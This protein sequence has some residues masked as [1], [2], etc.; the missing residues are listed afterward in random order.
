MYTQMV[1]LEG[2]NVIVYMSIHTYGHV[3]GKTYT[4]YW[5]VNNH[6]WK[7]QKQN[8]L[9]GIGPFFFFVDAILKKTN[10]KSLHIFCFDVPEMNNADLLFGL[11]LI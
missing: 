10:Q 4:V 3:Q 11:E 8:I 7:K 6:K 2:D 5:R 9:A 1:L